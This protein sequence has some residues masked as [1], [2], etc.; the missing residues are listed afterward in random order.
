M[1]SKELFNKRV[2]EDIGL[3][4]YYS[5]YI[6]NSHFLLFLTITLGV[7]IYSLIGFIQEAEPSIWYLVVGSVIASL[8]VLPSYRSLLKDADG[9]FLL[10]YEK[11]MKTY[12]QGANRYSFILN[13][14]LVMLGISVSSL[15]IS[16]NLDLWHIIIVAI[17]ALVI[18]LFN[19]FIYRTAVNSAWNHWVV[20]GLLFVLGAASLFIVMMFVSFAPF[21]PVLL[22]GVYVYFTKQGSKHLNWFRYINHEKDARNRYF[23]M[24]SMFANVAHMDSQYKRRKYLDGLLPNFKN[25]AF[26]KKNM[27][28][29]LFYRSFLRDNDLP[30]IVF[31]LIIIGA[32]IMVWLNIWYVSLIIGVFFIYL[33]VLQMNQIY[34]QQAY[35]LWPKIWP[36]K[37]EYIQES[38]I[39]YSNKL[40]LVLSIV[41]AV[42]YLAVHVEHFYIAAIFPVWGY[43]INKVLSKGIYKKERMLSD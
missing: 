36:V 2:K 40:V 37:R 11:H 4:A 26:H 32:I 31:R 13:I 20:L 7:F 30:M 15:L 8:F 28:E 33:I 22:I 5:K 19:L 6:F 29:Y 34:S 38:Y 25:S 9:L 27:Y 10:A 35:L 16:I 3:R 17:A 18:Y 42:I 1:N 23:R 39:R 14:V 41:I 24:V 12:F 21:V 43:L